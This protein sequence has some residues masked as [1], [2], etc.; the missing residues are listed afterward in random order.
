[1][2]GPRE[3]LEEFAAAESSAAARLYEVV[4]YASQA[5]PGIFYH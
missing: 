5:R 3:L 2:H 1:M 4:K